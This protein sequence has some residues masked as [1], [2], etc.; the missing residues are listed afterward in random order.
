MYIR[1]HQLSHMYALFRATFYKKSKF[2]K[3]S[4][5]K[6]HLSLA[7][8]Q[9]YVVK[10]LLIILSHTGGQCSEPSQNLVIVYYLTYGLCTH[11]VGT[12]GLCHPII[13]QA[14]ECGHMQA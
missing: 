9:C 7:L 4:S 3:M 2:Y 12:H 8:L 13:G 5:C 11:T 14:A 6:S 10:G 1:D